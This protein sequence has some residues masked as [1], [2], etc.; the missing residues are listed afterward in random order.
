MQ[1]GSFAVNADALGL[2]PT[3]LDMGGWSFRVSMM[4]NGEFRADGSV[5]NAC[6]AEQLVGGLCRFHHKEIS[7]PEEGAGLVVVLSQGD[8][9]LKPQTLSIAVLE[10][11]LFSP[12]Q[13]MPD[14]PE[15]LAPCPLSTATGKRCSVWRRLS[16]R[17]AAA[18]QQDLTALFLLLLRCLQGGAMQLG[19]EMLVS[20]PVL[21]PALSALAYNAVQT[22]HGNLRVNGA[23]STSFT[24]KDVVNGGVLFEHDL[25]DWQPDPLTPPGSGGVRLEVFSG[26][27]V[28][29]EDDMLLTFPVAQDIAV[30]SSNRGGSVPAVSPPPPPPPPAAPTKLPVPTPVQAQTAW[31]GPGLA[32][33]DSFYADRFFRGVSQDGVLHLT[34]LM[35]TAQDGA[36]DPE[37][38]IYSVLSV[39][40]GALTL[41]GEPLLSGFFT[42]QDINQGSVAF[43][44]RPNLSPTDAEAKLSFSISHKG[45]VYPATSFVVS[46]SPLTMTGAVV[47][48]V[49]LGVL[50]IGPR[51]T[52]QIDLS[53]SG[54]PD[55]VLI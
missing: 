32:L 33:R 50:L 14:L 25:G 17:P 34:G 8:M 16:A 20:G 5:S 11:D 2:T 40:N 23:N 4:F 31:L 6:S 10:S 28:I 42:Q 12:A 53:H 54:L 52:R 48:K 44:H 29:S 26:D 46:I 1:G 18:Q 7:S 47:Q 30:P 3:W 21:E 49:S 13:S 15:V 22:F 27:Q 55:S 24:H 38:W 37:T 51:L 43:V 35:L 39:Q 45:V 36:T 19:P 9:V 41:N